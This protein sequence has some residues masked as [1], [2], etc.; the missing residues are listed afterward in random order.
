MQ[1]NTKLIK[2]TCESDSKYVDQRA[3]STCCG[4]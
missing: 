1:L 2:T 3:L 4:I